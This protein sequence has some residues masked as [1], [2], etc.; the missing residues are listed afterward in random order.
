M[1]KTNRSRKDKKYFLGGS[2]LSLQINKRKSEDLDFCI[3]S[4]NLK[5]DKPVVHWPAIEKE[6]E[7]AGKIIVL[8]FWSPFMM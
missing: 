5:K 3:W 6:L 2:A 4:K 8:P 7:T 1:G